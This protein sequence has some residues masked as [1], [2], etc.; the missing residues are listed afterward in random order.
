SV[1]PGRELGTWLSEE[2]I[3]AY[4]KLHTLGHAHSV[5][6]WNEAELVG[7]IYGVAVGGAFAGESMFHR[8]RDGSKLALYYLIE[9][10]TKQ[11]FRLL[12]IQQWT[13]HTGS[14]GAIEVP[15]E[16]FLKRLSGLV[17]M[18]VEFRP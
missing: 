14:L 6:V 7:G 4:V 17:G 12:D 18:R 2:M 15:R 8:Q 16:D 9:H 1:G 13:E 11:G 5:E 3:A 10:L